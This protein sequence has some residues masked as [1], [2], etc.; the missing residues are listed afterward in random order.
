MTT[1]HDFKGLATRLTGRLVLPED[2][3]Y[4]RLR[5]PVLGGLTEL[6]PQAVARCRTTSDV[7]EALAFARK[8]GLS[9]AVRSGGHSFADFCATDGLLIDLAEMDTV[10]VDGDVATVGPGVRMAGLADGLIAHGRIA[11]C[12]WC[13]TVAV[14]GSVLGGGYGVLSRYLGLGCDHLVAAEVVLADGEVV[15]VDADHEPDLFWALRGAGTGNFGIVTSLVL[16]TYPARPIV[17]FVHEW[18]WSSVVDVIDTWQRWAPEAPPH[19][20]MELVIQTNYP[21]ESDPRVVVFGAVVAPAAEARALLEEF[22]HQVDPRADL[23]ELTELSGKVAT[24]RHSYAGRPEF[25]FVEPGPPMGVRPRLRAVKSE[26]F[27]QPMPREAVEALVATFTADPRPMQYRELEF[28]PW[29]GAFARVA[30][31]E[32]AF[33]HRNARFLIGHHAIAGNMADDEAR[34]ACLDF[35]RRSW[36]SVHPWASGAVYGN[37]P[38]LALDDW[39]RAYYGDN[40]PRLRQVKA[41]YDPENVFRFAQSVPPPDGE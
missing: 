37:Y 12:G 6:L 2:E 31:S 32:T 13:P 24:R 19:V 40:F 17:R 4:A 8:S 27:D 21:F 30:P 10:E 9:F 11:P 20:N 1:E 28:V 22:V 38:D 41:A 18:P 23:E 29:G 26:Y 15:R 34:Q 36:D 33:P 25:P 35:V 7:V 5:K 39:G 16:R 14:A 3:E